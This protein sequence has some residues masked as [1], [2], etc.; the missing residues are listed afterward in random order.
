MAMNAIYQTAITFVGQNYGAGKK[1]RVLRC[2]LQ[3]EAIVVIV[4]LFFGV[5]AY[6]F[7]T[8]LLHI[9]S[10]SP[11][12]VEAGKIR[13]AYI[14][15]IYFVWF[16]GCNGWSIKRYWT[17]CCTYG[18]IINRSMCIEACLDFNSIQNAQNYRNAIYF[19]SDFMDNYFNRAYCIFCIFL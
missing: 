19:I 11:A 4:G 6:I 8:E 7:S 3:A 15:P 5:S 1:K 2:T 9:Y 14:L 12:V 18:N 13:C 16:N 10:G 17:V